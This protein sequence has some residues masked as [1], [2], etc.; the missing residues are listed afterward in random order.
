MCFEA[1][2]GFRGRHRAH[3]PHVLLLPLRHSSQFQEEA[4]KNDSWPHLNSCEEEEARHQAPHAAISALEDGEQR[5]HRLRLRL[6]PADHARGP[7]LRPSEGDIDAIGVE[8]GLWDLD[9]RSELHSETWR[10]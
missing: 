9:L 2:L 1:V 10:P 6:L 4:F 3:L 7:R 5:D 8:A